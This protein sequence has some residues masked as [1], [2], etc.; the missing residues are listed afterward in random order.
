MR[1]R[2]L[3]L[4]G[5]LR[6][7]SMHGYR[8][9]EFIEHELSICTD[10][11]K[12]T[13]YFL[14]DKLEQAG[15]IAV[16]EAIQDSGRPPRKM[17]AITPAGEAAF[18]ALLRDHLRELDLSRFTADAGF[19]FIDALDPAESIDLLEARR[20]ALAAALDE[21]RAAP[22]HPGALNFVIRQRI[23]HLEAEYDW[24]ESVIQELRASIHR[25]DS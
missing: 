6:R 11:K 1:S 21:A 2:Q 15:W 12:P 24:L 5:L 9:N 22:P 4:L 13:A 16:T 19:A 17:Y 10:L 23:A 14:L 20:A 18:Q 7:E 25:E 3:L 8:L